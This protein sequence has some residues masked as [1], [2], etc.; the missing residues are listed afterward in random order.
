MPPIKI[1]GLATIKLLRYDDGYDD[2]ATPIPQPAR[3]SETETGCSASRF[4]LRLQ[5][6]KVD[7]T[8]RC[9][10]LKEDMSLNYI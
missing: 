9:E 2:S 5:L 8:N 7:M 10:A 3:G 6:N 4:T 1:L